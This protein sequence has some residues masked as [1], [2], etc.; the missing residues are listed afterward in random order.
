MKLN[1][2]GAIL[3]LFNHQVRANNIK[4]DEQKRQ[5]SAYFAIM[6]I[7]LDVFAV[8]T[9]VVGAWLLIN[10]ESA[11]ILLIFSLIIGISLLI[12][13]VT[14]IINSLVHLIYQFTINRSAW[15]WIALVMFLLTLAGIAVGIILLI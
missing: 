11:S 9:A 8:A 6:S 7:I 13:A 1:I 2:F 15:T 12:G 4:Q 10:M 3:H 5:K 14:L